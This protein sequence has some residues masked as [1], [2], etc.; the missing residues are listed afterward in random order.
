MTA[1]A[2]PR[3][4][5]CD[6]DRVSVTPTTA[7]GAKPG[8]EPGVA[9]GEEPGAA[10]EESSSRRPH[11]RAVL[12]E[13]E[14]VTPLEL[15]FDLVFVLAL[16]QCT[17]LIAH[18]PTWLG[19]ARGM[20][21]L[22]VLWWAW[23]GYAWLTSVVD[24]EEGAVRLAIFAAM[25]ALLVSALCVPGA[26]GRD[27][28]LFACAYGVVRAAHIALFVLA[29]R[30]DP[31]LR[32]SVQGLAASTA[33]GVAILLGAAFTGGALQV[34]LWVLAVVLD[35]GGPYLFGADGWKLM[36]GHF[37]ERHGA[38]VIIALGES[39]VALGVGAHERLDLGVVTAAVLGVLVAAALWWLYFDVVALAAQRRLSR[40]AAGRERNE[41]AR[42]A[43]SYLHLPMVAGIAL[44]AVGLK[45]TLE[46]VEH[47]LALVPAAALLGG[48]A[49]YLLAHVGFR[50]RNMRSL[51]RRRL[52]CA[53]LLLAL[54]PAALAVK[55]PALVTLAMLAGVL[56]ALIAYEALRFAE[57]RER[58][59]HKQPSSQSLAK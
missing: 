25:A 53:L 37:A 50:L 20:L 29:S 32:H 39:I 3:S 16:T 18:E 17:T 55:P 21:V 31:E 42:D 52:L 8:E 54:L 19:V 13:G 46:H 35:T 41:L 5:S 4:C 56:T 36:P 48:A 30:E 43:Y 58:I 27:A 1:R 14:R 57:A 12:R 47:P 34:A 11:V 44:I 59:R 6:H 24:P 40:T 2:G 15:F 9:V 10:V 38:I 49:V 7:S 23:G 33:L 28:L 51:N 26:F 45:E 22:A